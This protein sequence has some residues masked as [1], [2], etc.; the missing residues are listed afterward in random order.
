[1]IN[2]IMSR[3]ILYRVTLARDTYFSDDDALFHL[4][5]CFVLFHRKHG[6]YI[7]RKNVN[8]KFDSHNSITVWLTDWHIKTNNIKK[9][10]ESRGSPTL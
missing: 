6:A 2:L 8:N 10:G 5:G 4:F 1:M 9:S 7:I 3:W